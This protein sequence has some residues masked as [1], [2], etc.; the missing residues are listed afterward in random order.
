MFI[1][2]TVFVVGAGA[3]A[4]ANLPVGSGLVD[5]IKA[6][7]RFKLSTFGESGSGGDSNLYQT[8]AKDVGHQRAAAALSQCREIS[9]SLDHAD[10]IDAYMNEFRH[11]PDVAKYAKL[12]IAY[13]IAIAESGSKLVVNRSNVSN[14]LNSDVTKS[15]WYN[16]FFRSLRDGVEFENLDSI[17]RNVSIICFNY[18]RCIEQYLFYSLRH[19]Y[20]VDPQRAIEVLR[21]LRIHRPYGHIGGF[22]FDPSTGHSNY[23]L[24][25]N[26]ISLVEQ[27]KTLRTVYEGNADSFAL[28]DIHDELVSAKQIVF[29]GFGFHK[30]NMELLAPGKACRP[31]R[32]LATA[33]NVPRPSLSVI[34]SHI[35]NYLFDYPSIGETEVDQNVIEILPDKSCGDLL[36]NYRLV[37]TDG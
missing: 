16:H 23:G 30:L 36:A 26:G 2:P 19:Y 22:N 34:R 11:N 15:T 21:T 4:E 25:L 20:R 14:T 27:S 17:F 33:K 24:H 29:L 31:K 35:K 9:Y 32:L 6:G 10:S 1:S 12:A 5:Q 37:L 8:I 13:Y 28:K 18:D 3:S 7:L